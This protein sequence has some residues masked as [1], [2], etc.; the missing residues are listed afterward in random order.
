MN[1][2]KMLRRDVVWAGQGLG[3]VVSVLLLWVGLLV[4]QYAETQS[5]RRSAYAREIDRLARVRDV[6]AETLAARLGQIDAIGNVAEDLAKAIRH[7]DA[8]EF[9][10]TS[11]ALRLMLQG[12]L[13]GTYPGVIQVAIA[14]A[15]G[16]GVW[17]ST[18]GHETGWNVADREHFQA[19]AGGAARYVGQPV[20]GRSSGEVTSQFTRAL[21]DESGAFAGVAVISVAP[22]S[23]TLLNATFEIDEHVDVWV[24][25]K[26][27]LPISN[28]WKLEQ[29]PE[30][31]LAAGFRRRLLAGQDCGKPTPS[32]VS[33]VPRLRACSEPGAYDLALIVATDEALVA[34]RV[35][36]AV[37]RID[38]SIVFAGVIIGLAGAIGLMYLHF[39]RREIVNVMEAQVRR[40][41][42]RRFRLLAENISDA[43]LLI[44]RESR[45]APF[46]VYATP[47]CREVLGWQADAGLPSLLRRLS[48]ASDRQIVRQVLR[49]MDHEAVAHSDA[50]RLCRPDGSVAWLECRGRT[51]GGPDAQGHG[52]VYVL[53]LRDVSARINAVR[54]LAHAHAKLERLVANTPGVI[55]ET[56]VE[57]QPGDRIVLKSASLTRARGVVESG[58]P[59]EDVVALL[60]LALTWKGGR[61]RQNLLRQAALEG[62]A[63][64]E[65]EAQDPDGNPRILRD[66]ITRLAGADGATTLAGYLLDVTHENDMI[67]NLVK[68]STLI[69]LGEMASAIAHELHQ[70]LAAI[71]LSAHNGMRLAETGDNREGVLKKFDQIIKFVTRAAG[72]VEHIR[73][74]SRGDAKLQPFGLARAVESALTIMEAPLRLASVVTAVELEPGLP[75]LMGTPIGF[76]QV[77]INLLS[78]AIDAFNA[79]QV[80]APRVVIRASSH[81]RLVQVEVADNAGGIP[82]D[83]IG[84]VFVPFFTTKAPGRGMGLG[85]ALSHR[86][87]QEMGGTITVEN[88][89]EGACFIIIVPIVTDGAAAA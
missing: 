10:E 16:E 7:G 17:S 68:S 88:R 59:G 31:A 1:F 84:R 39:R 29:F 36:M 78:N 83:V 74:L 44:A 8:A 70:R 66:R 65:F 24:V 52:S 40:D 56:D 13:K 5:E 89:G 67:Q 86:T 33:K 73:L 20:V 32:P 79:R 30:N 38:A 47:S 14:D 81:G 27:G 21:H 43:V 71:S 87:L 15:K 23:L 9:R 82:A 22:T 60:G 46:L 45:R 53:A 49:S 57:L 37:R 48:G 72:V 41:A 55:Y 51:I 42:M 28:Y 35:D 75:L 58:R 2:R 11:D 6:L 19:A 77:M 18:P 34:R 54:E 25:R 85:M 76:E 80:A 62:D 3:I 12:P 61:D 4:L 26:D 64:G 69:T 50:F 63:V